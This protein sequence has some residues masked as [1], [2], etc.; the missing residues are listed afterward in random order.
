M[1]HKTE[2]S[3]KVKEDRPTRR[4]RQD[5]IR[6][7]LYRSPASSKSKSFRKLEGT[8]K[9]YIQTHVD[10][11]RI[12]QT[13]EDMAVGGQE[14]IN[15]YGLKSITRP[16]IDAIRLLLLYG[17]G[18]PVPQSDTNENAKDALNKFSEISKDVFTPEVTNPTE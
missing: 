11:H 1:K 4:K 15:G 18:A 8:L 17:F 16:D 10:W 12:I 5:E 6:P 2:K 14:Y 9:N 7:D 13:L 3:D